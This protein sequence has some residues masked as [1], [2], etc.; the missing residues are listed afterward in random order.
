[1]AIFRCTGCGAEG[2]FHTLGI[3][4]LCPNCGSADAVRISMTM[5]DYPAG[6][7]FWNELAGVNDRSDEALGSATDKKVPI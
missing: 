5:D 7:P 1:M 3:D 6:H 2:D 4:Q